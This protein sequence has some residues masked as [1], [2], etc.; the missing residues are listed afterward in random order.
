MDAIPFTDTVINGNLVGDGIEGNLAI[1]A[2][3]EGICLG[4]NSGSVKNLTRSRYSMSSHG[5]GGAVVR[6]LGSKVHYITTLE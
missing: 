2:S 1:W 6:K 5:I 4:D 3:A